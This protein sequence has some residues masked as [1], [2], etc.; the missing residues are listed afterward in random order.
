MGASGRTV[1]E[2]KPNGAIAEE[3]VAAAE[4]AGLQ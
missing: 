1:A 3:M 4:E 2:P